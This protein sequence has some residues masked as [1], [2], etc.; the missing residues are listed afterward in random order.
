MSLEELENII[1]DFENNA[2]NDKDGK[3]NEENARKIIEEKYSKYKNY[4]Q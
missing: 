3:I 4:M 1:I 2:I